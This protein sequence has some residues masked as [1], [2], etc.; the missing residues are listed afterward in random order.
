MDSIAKREIAESC[1]HINGGLVD[2]RYDTIRNHL[3]VLIPIFSIPE[4]YLS[5]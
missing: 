5:V 1:E 3:L 2:I 4:I